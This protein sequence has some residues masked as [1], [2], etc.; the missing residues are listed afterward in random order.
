MIYVADDYNVSGENRMRP[1]FNHGD[2]G[3]FRRRGASFQIRKGD[4]AMRN[5][6]FRMCRASGLSSSLAI[7]GKLIE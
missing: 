1:R 4:A 2:V 5:D 3:L 6:T 7:E